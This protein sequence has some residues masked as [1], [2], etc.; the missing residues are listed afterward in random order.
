MK[1]ALIT[2]LALTPT[3]ALAE[4]TDYRLNNEVDLSERC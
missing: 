4:Q 3:A 2:L 1:I